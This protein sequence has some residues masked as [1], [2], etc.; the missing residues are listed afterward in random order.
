MNIERW[1]PVKGYEGIYEV[2][3]IGRIRQGFKG[4]AK[5]SVITFLGREG[6]MIAVL[7]K[8]KVEK[9]HRIHRL[10]YEAFIGKINGVI[11][12]IDGIKTNNMLINL[13]DVTQ[14]ENV[15]RYYSSKKNKED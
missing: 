15:R 3:S 2:S 1:M 9:Q 11:D 14:K 12:H 4:S 10:V 13:E 5:K 6:Y 7:V 8:F